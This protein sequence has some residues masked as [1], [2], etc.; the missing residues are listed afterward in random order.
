[1]S[2]VTDLIIRISTTG[3]G[4]SD[5]AGMGGSFTSAAMGITG[6]ASAFDLLD[7]AVGAVKAGIGVITGAA[8]DLIAVG[9][10]FE[11]LNVRFETIFGGKGPAQKALDWAV[12][13]AAKTPLTMEE[14]TS[15]MLKMKVYGFDPMAGSLESIGNAAFALGA[16][17]DGIVTALGQMANKGK[18]SQ[19]E[20]NQLAERGVPAMRWLKEE[21]NLTSKQLGNIGNAGLDV[22]KVLKIFFGKFD[23]EYAGAMRRASDTWAGSISTIS[24][25]WTIFKKDIMDAGPFAFLVEK[26]RYIRDEF[27][28]MATGPGKQTAAMI[29]ITITAAL[30]GSWKIIMEKIIPGAK[31]LFTMTKA[32]LPSI[33]EWWN[34]T[35]DIS[36]IVAGPLLLGVRE[37]SKAMWS[38]DYKSFA[39]AIEETFF[40]LF[41][42]ITQGF[43]TIWSYAA[44]GWYTF[45]AGVEN[46][47]NNIGF[48]IGRVVEDLLI[49][50]GIIKMFEY[51]GAPT[52]GLEAMAGNLIS[53][54]FKN[55]SMSDTI[56]E[57]NLKWVSETTG[58][59]RGMMDMIQLETQ[60]IANIFDKFKID[61]S[62][63]FGLGKILGGKDA[64][65]KTVED[66]VIKA[67]QG[68]V[69]SQ[70]TTVKDEWP[71][72]GPFNNLGGGVIQGGAMSGAAIGG[73]LTGGAVTAGGGSASNSSR[74]KM[75]VEYNGGDEIVRYVIDRCSFYA[76][77]EGTITAGV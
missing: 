10:T 63:P 28:A 67:V 42:K 58:I 32:A 13:F 20:I 38:L 73:A 68:P 15:R 71:E 16:D 41:D 3:N 64:T 39:G 44:Q 6:I 18:V 5:L 23:T 66:A 34:I 24:D 17:F 50:P 25:T 37:I 26:I 49:D 76:K 51:I 19:E 62:D 1:M 72:T 52:A 57:A 65:K 7:R 60:G 35:M 8:A 4:P 36:G 75:E 29:G 43:V 40:W 59:A 77:S 61:P 74:Q 9:S 47:I 48:Q 11:T 31:E 55:M 22:Q 56:L 30:E 69:V 33:V 27:S 46:G 21:F 54:T 12:E 70:K 45:S 14:V 53:S 2:I